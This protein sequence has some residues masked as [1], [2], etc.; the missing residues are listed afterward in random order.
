MEDRLW[1]KILDKL[2]EEALEKLNNLSEET[3]SS[4]QIVQILAESGID[5]TSL[6]EEVKME[7]QQNG[8]Q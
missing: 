1:Q 5:F 3:V 2:P 6:V 4:E 8:K 7:E